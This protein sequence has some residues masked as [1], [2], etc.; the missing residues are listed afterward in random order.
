MAI[1]FLLSNLSYQYGAARL[2]SGITSVVMITEVLFAA[3]SAIVLGNEAMT[4][5]LMVGGGLIVIAAVLAVRARP[6]VAARAPG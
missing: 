2:P 3:G 6:V 4:A 1:A 5:A